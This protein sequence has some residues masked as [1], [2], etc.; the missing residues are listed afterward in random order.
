MLVWSTIAIVFV[1]VIVV[2]LAVALSASRRAKRLRH[3][4]DPLAP[5]TTEDGHAARTA[6]AQGSRPDGGTGFPGGPS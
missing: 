1:L 5:R 2:A 6:R 3:L 4:D